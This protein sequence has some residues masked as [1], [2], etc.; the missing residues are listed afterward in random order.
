MIKKKEK[1]QYMWKFISRHPAQRSDVQIITY[2]QSCNYGHSNF[3]WKLQI[4]LQ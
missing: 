1:T 3:N 2:D 4:M